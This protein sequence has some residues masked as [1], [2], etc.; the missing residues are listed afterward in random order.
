MAK[1]LDGALQ[2][3]VER[4]LSTWQPRDEAQWRRAATRYRRILAAEFVLCLGLVAAGIWLKAEFGI[5]W[6]AV[7]MKGGGALWLIMLVVQGDIWGLLSPEADVGASPASSAQIE[8]IEQLSQKLS[9]PLRR[10]LAQRIGD[11]KQLRA[12]DADA[13]LQ[14]ISDDRRADRRN[15]AL[16]RLDLA[17][18]RRGA[19]DAHAGQ[20]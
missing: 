10:K 9:A 19:R 7:A 18:A 13:L 2:T 5:G 6:Q 14:S 8:R 4:A 16:E 11:I 12:G 17:I 20:I 1:K 3:A 15:L